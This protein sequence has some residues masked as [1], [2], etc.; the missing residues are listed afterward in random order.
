ML[1]RIGTRLICATIRHAD[2]T[3]K[4]YADLGTDSLTVADGTYSPGGNRVR[5]SPL[6]W[7]CTGGW[8]RVQPDRSAADDLRQALQAILDSGNFDFGAVSL[9]FGQ[10]FTYMA[11]RISTRLLVEILGPFPSRLTVLIVL[12]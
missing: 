11:F 12:A 4:I 8:G 9:I 10:R 5:I 6:Q 2:L 7:H 3:S 1:P